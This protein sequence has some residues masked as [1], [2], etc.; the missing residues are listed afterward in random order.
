M[1][2]KRVEGKVLASGPE[3]GLLAMV[4]CLRRCETADGPPVLLHVGQKEGKEFGLSG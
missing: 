1:G 2:D 4:S 3:S